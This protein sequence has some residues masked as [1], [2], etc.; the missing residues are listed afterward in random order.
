V[1]GGQIDF[2]LI[3]FS[4]EVWFHFSGYVNSQNNRHWPAENPML[5]QKVP[6]HD[7]KFGVCGAMSANKITEPI[8]D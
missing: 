3:L 6:L 5:I 4:D 1:H 8:F 7:I 2:T